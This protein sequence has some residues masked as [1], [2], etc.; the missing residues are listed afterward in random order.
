MVLTAHLGKLVNLK[1]P[2]E[3]RVRVSRKDPASG[4]V[5]RMRLRWM[6]CLRAV[7]RCQVDNCV[8]SG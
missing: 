5:D 7:V 6:L 2:G 1:K 8:F 4:M 3:Y